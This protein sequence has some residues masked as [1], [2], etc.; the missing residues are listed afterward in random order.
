MQIE[1]PPGNKRKAVFDLRAISCN[2]RE[3]AGMQIGV[4]TLSAGNSATL[5]ASEAD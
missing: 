4:R 1:L 5:C 2:F 3:L